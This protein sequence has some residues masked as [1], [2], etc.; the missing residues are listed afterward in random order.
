MDR[1]DRQKRVE[2][3]SN[4]LP[5]DHQAAIFLLEPGKLRSAWQRGTTFLIHLPRFFLIFQTRFGSCARI[6]RF[7]NTCRSPLAS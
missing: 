3:C 2:A 5:P 4:A 7:R 1:G 6:P